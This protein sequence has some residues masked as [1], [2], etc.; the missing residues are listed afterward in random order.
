MAVR[1]LLWVAHRWQINSD[2]ESFGLPR[3]K[4]M[5]G[6]YLRFSAGMMERNYQGFE[7]VKKNDYILGSP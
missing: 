7:L 5:G 4:S 2:T 6:S 3:I 1:A